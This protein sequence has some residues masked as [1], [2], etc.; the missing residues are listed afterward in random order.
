M[1]SSGAAIALVALLAS[2]ARADQTSPDVPLPM[3]AAARRTISGEPI[4]PDG[5][6]SESEE[7]RV[8]REWESRTFGPL[9]RRTSRM[10]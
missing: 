5:S 2:F 3:D 7:L 8:L 4:E 10:R 6:A 1:R 9:G